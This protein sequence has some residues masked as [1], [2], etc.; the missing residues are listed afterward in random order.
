MM[1]AMASSR[2]L[3]ISAISEECH[4]QLAG[5]CRCVHSLQTAMPACCG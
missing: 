4:K 3:D 1:Q 5:S 2:L